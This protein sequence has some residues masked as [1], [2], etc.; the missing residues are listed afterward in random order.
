[1][2]ALLADV[3]GILAPPVF[4]DKAKTASAA[5]NNLLGWMMLL[6]ISP[7]LIALAFSVPSLRVLVWIAAS[8]LGALA[9]LLIALTHLGH[10]NNGAALFLVGVWALFSWAA[11]VS[12]GV[13][14][15][16]ICAQFLVVAL[17]EATRRWRWAVAAGTLSL[18]TVA[19]FTWAALEEVVPA[20]AVVTTPI[21]YGAIV[22]AC[23]L[24]L[25][26]T[27][28]LIGAQTR[29]AG[30]RVVRELEVRAAAEQRL[31]NLVDNAPFGAFL[32]DLRDGQRL[33]V[34]HANRHAS[35]A[36]GKDA[37]QFVGGE[38]NLAFA[39]SD[40]GGLMEQFC[41][42]AA[43]GEAFEG[44][45]IQIHSGGAKR[46]LDV[47]AYQTEPNTIAVF[48][49]DVTQQRLAEARI[50]QAA[51]HDELTSLPN[52]KLLLDRLGVAID[53]G[54]RRKT[55]VALLFIDLDNFKP[56]NDRYG[57]AFGDLVLSAVGKLLIMSVR[58]SD[59]VARIGGD[60]FTVLMPD[61][62]N[63]EQAEVVASKIVESFHEPVGING[64]A[65]TITASVGVTVSTDHDVGPHALLE[66]ADKAMYQ[67]KRS[68]RDGYRF[69]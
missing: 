24:G 9:V 50:R 33:T 5:Y 7:A 43:Q 34:S 39:T 2:A 18:T 32:A 49:S 35:V 58:S 3:R 29:W 8:A 37:S 12:G 61:V 40:R 1:L 45:E 36:L 19:V 56:L 13:F 69:L 54:K 48:F 60:E 55:G 30:Q 57:H 47:H 4:D 28:G 67:M 52:R 53:V 6:I 20:S 10:V 42:V 68:G 51:Y 16:A 15:A 21:S 31:L 46:T 27:H 64:R 44:E 62:A 66:L 11:W 26:I 59:T 41:R 17:A 14:S 23:L 38:L 65:I 63:R 22:G 25:A